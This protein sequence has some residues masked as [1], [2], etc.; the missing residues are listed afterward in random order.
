MS[1]HNAPSMAHIA[2]TLEKCAAVFPG[3]CAHDAPLAVLPFGQFTIRCRPSAPAIRAV[4]AKYR[5]GR[6]KGPGL[7]PYSERAAYGALRCVGPYEW[8]RA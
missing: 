2:D 7:K 3:E 6:L 5:Y 4:A 1:T 8:W